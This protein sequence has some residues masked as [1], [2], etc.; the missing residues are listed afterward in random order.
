MKESSIAFFERLGELEGVLA[1]YPLNRQDPEMRDSVGRE[2]EGVVRK[3][4]EAF[5]ARCQNKG[6]E[7]CECII[8]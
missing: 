3:G 1:R 4:Y 2:V 7:K 6:A 8:P 5:A